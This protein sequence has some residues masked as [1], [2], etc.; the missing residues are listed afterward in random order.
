MIWPTPTTAEPGPHGKSAS[1]RLDGPRPT[2]T[3]VTIQSK[4]DD[5]RSRALPL[6]WFPTI[7]LSNQWW[8]W[9]FAPGGST[10]GENSSGPN[11]DQS[12]PCCFPLLFLSLTLSLSVSPC[13]SLSL[14]LCLSLPLSLSSFFR[15]VS[16]PLPLPLPLP[17]SLSLSLSLA[18]TRAHSFALGLASPPKHQRS[19]V[20]VCR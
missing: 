17:L 12:S 11:Q 5:R 7:F 14:C 3:R 15:S 8:R 9:K 19:I 10:S 13:I 2:Q 18:R 1:R 16:L 6:R 4:A 20:E